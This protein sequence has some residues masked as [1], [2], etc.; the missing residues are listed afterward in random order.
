MANLNE[1]KKFHFIYKTT[2][3]KNDKYYIG[4]HS[5]CNLNDGYLGSGTYLR[6]AIR[7]HGIECFQCEILEHFT[8]RQSLVIR[9][10]E[11]ITAEVILDEKCMNLKPGGYGGFN[12]EEHRL[13]CSLAG[14]TAAAKSGNNRKRIKWLWE[15]DKEWASKVSTA[16]SVALKGKPGTFIGKHHTIET[17]QKMKNVRIVRHLGYGDENSQYGTQWITNGM[18]SKKNKKN[19]NM[20]EG[21]YIGRVMTKNEHV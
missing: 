20:P 17:T 8:D 9:E 2:N 15:N 19:Q 14:T 16:L 13:K 5:T 1:K 3:L 7:K 4:M 10:K 21:W 12:N 11:L 6:R 18:E